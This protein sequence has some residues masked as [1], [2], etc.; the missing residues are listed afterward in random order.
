MA[1][2]YWFGDG[3]NWSDTAHWGTASNGVGAPAA[4]PTNADDVYFDVNSFTIDGQTVTL[5]AT[6]FCKAMDWAG[7]TNTPTVAVGIYRF[8]VYGSVTF[9]AA[10]VI[11]N[12]TS[13]LLRFRATGTFTS[14]GQVFN[15]SH[16]Y[17]IAGT[18]TLADNFACLRFYHSGG[19]LVTGGNDFTIAQWWVDGAGAKTIILGASAISVSQWIDNSGSNITVTANTATITLTGTAYIDSV[20]LDWNGATLNLTGSAHA[21][22]SS[23]TFAALTTPPGTTQ[24]LTFTAGT[25]QKITGTLTLSGDATHQHTLVATGAGSIPLLVC[26]TLADDFVTYTGVKAQA[27]IA[28]YWDFFTWA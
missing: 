8:D 19:T 4:V 7:A 28:A 1:D 18:T 27:L 21:I 22:T 6:S 2:R 20:G 16:I 23:G 9:I 3:G 5:T 17:L 13:L 24:T 25:R 10:M 12:T 26:I 15:T 11:T 14:N